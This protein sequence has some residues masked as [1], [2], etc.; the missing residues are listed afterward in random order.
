[1]TKVF[2]NLPTRD[3]ERA[4]TFYP[5][6]VI[7]ALEAK[8]PMKTSLG[9]VMYRPEDHQLIRPVPVMRGKKPSEMKSKD[10]YYEVVKMIPGT[11]AVPPIDP[12]CKMG[13]LT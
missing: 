6:E 13:E 7:K 5:P 1:M 10:D 2:V 3:L 9:D 12:A 4:K 8:M 11:D